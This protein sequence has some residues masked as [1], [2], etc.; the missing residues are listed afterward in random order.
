MA[1]EREPT[2]LGVAACQRSLARDLH[3]RQ[4]SHRNRP[5]RQGSVELSNRGEGYPSTPALMVSSLPSPS[6][7]GEKTALRFEDRT[8]A[9]L[10]VLLFGRLRGDHGRRLDRRRPPENGCRHPGAAE[11]RGEEIRPE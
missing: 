7:R 4:P 6:R 2:D 11:N 1:G 8:H 9:F 3:A 5:K 10:L